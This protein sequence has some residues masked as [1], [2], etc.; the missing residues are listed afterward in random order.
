MYSLSLVV[1][2]LAAP[3]RLMFRTKEKAEACTAL[4][5]DHPTQD[6]RLEDDFGQ[7]LLAKGNMIHGK[8]LE[9]M[10]ESMLAYIETTVFNEK[11]KAKAIQRMKS[12]PMFGPTQ[13]Q[14]IV[15]PQFN[16]GIPQ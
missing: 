4:M 16:G 10:D 8:L 14:G 11:I 15:S 9:N 12:D 3:L 2:N 6:L 1:G 5:S 13:R 7:V